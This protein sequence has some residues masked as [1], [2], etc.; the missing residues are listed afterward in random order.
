MKHIGHPLF[1]DLEY[2]G[3]RILKG[4]S[5]AKYKR[6]IENCFELLPGQ[7]L[8]AKTLGFQH[9]V[10][11]DYVRLDSELPAGFSQVLEKWDVYTSALD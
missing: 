8:H 6:F 3:D 11:S 4:T 10:K 7:A 9:P 2:G 5:N 1:N